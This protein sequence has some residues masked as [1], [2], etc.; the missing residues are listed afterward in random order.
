MPFRGGRLQAA[1]RLGDTPV[2]GTYGDAQRGQ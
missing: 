2:R 1:A